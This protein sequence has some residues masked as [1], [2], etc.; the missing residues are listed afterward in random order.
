MDTTLINKIPELIEMDINSG[1][2]Q[3]ARDS[4]NF[5][6][7]NYGDRA[8]LDSWKNKINPLVKSIQEAMS[9]LK[10][11]E[12]IGKCYL[13]DATKK[14]EWFSAEKKAHEDSIRKFNAEIEKHKK[15]LEFY[16]HLNSLRNRDIESNPQKT[17]Q[18]SQKANL[19]GNIWLV[20]LIEAIVSFATWVIQRE[21]LGIDNIITR[22]VFLFSIGMASVYQLYLYQK[23]GKRLLK[24][25]H[26]IILLLGFVCIIDGLFVGYYWGTVTAA[27]STDFNLDPVS[28]E[29]Q[30]Y[31]AEGISY[32]LKNFPGIFEFLVTVLITFCG[33]MIAVPKMKASAE[34][35]AKT[36]KMESIIDIKIAMTNKAIAE[37]NNKI[38]EENA[39]FSKIEEINNENLKASQAQ[40][41][42]YETMKK[43]CD[44]TISEKKDELENHLDHVEEDM[45]QYRS[46]FLEARSMQ[47][48]VPVQSLPPY[49]LATKSDIKNYL[50]KYHSINI[51]L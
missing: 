25:M 9:K 23:T 10:K 28:V 14:R 30:I 44:D 16:N 33:K 1:A 49:E 5:R 43:A 11:I 29:P 3:P 15:K 45:A 6:T 48:D 13:D 22:I 42:D 34:V 41:K 2:K 7:T 47:L 17:K 50:K 35:S 27:P 37:V 51:D 32:F 4:Q 12:R 20:I 36:T 8:I 24:V 21:A 18:H 39:R 19:W 38:E 26:D 31:K 46:D 40:Q